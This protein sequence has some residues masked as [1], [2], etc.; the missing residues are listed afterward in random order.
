MRRREGLLNRALKAV[1][2]PQWLYSGDQIRYSEIP[3]QG[4]VS[5]SQPNYAEALSR[6]EKNAII[7]ACVDWI[8]KKV[9]GMPWILEERTSAGWEEVEDHP[10]LDLL[11]QPTP[12]HDSGTVFLPAVRDTLVHGTSY[13]LTSETMLGAVGELWWRPSSMLSPVRDSQGMLAGY[14]YVVNGRTYIYPPERVIR[15]Q[16][17][18][19]PA[20]PF[21]GVSPLESLGPEVW[22]AFEALRRSG[23]LIENVG[24]IGLVVSSSVDDPDREPMSDE[25]VKATRDYIQDR[26]T[27]TRRG[28]AMYFDEPMDVT[29]HVVNPSDWHPSTLLNFVEEHVAASYHVPPSVIGFSTGLRVSSVGASTEAH[30]RQ[31]YDDAILPTAMTLATQLSRQI[32]PSFGLTPRTNRL[33]QD[34]S[35]VLV[36]QDDEKQRAEIWE[37]RLRSGAFTVSEA[38]VDADLQVL[39]ADDVYL[40]GASV[41]ELP[42]GMTEAERDEANRP[43]PEEDPENP[44]EPPEQ[45]EGDDDDQE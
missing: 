45:E 14:R 37:I 30:L 25:D 10:I 41:I 22:L 12:M 5:V 36:L 26:T 34:T 8:A 20:N 3:G 1:P 7:M 15:V 24:D 2:L 44:L 16:L 28:E 17:G 21:L 42:R 23:N 43:D 29:R 27:G 11:W 31:A 4:W 19:Q 38:R 35:D 33:V 6:A 40:R 32:L 9:V 18:Q 13:F 39:P